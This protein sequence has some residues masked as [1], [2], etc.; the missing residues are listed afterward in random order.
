MSNST[1]TAVKLVDMSLVKARKAPVG[2][3]KGSAL[4]PTG[5]VHEA[6][7][8][9][10]QSFKK[11]V[12]IVK[13]LKQR[14]TADMPKSDD[15]TR[16]LALEAKKMEHLE[17]MPRTDNTFSVPPKKGRRCT[18]WKNGK[19]TEIYALT[20]KWLCRV[21][22]VGGDVAAP[23]SALY[24]ETSDLKVKQAIE[25]AT[26]YVYASGPPE[27]FIKRFIEGVNR[28]RNYVFQDIHVFQVLSELVFD[29]EFAAL[30]EETFETRL[31]EL[32][33]N[34][35]A[36]AGFPYDVSKEAEVPDDSQGRLEMVPVFAYIKADAMAYWDAC[37]AE[38]GANDLLR[39]YEE[40]PGHGLFKLKNKHEKVHLSEVETKIRP[41]YVPPAAPSMVWMMLCQWIGDHCPDIDKLLMLKGADPTFKV[42]T[43]KAVG[44]SWADGGC[45]RVLTHMFDLE[46]GELKIL[47]YTDD[48]FWM[49]KIRGKYYLAMIDIRQLDASLAAEYEKLVKAVVLAA[50]KQSALEAGADP[51]FPVGWENALTDLLRMALRGP[52]A[53]FKENIYNILGGLR[54]G[55][56]ITSFLNQVAASLMVANVKDQW[57][58]LKDWVLS[59]ENTMEALATFME[60]A[61]TA[62]S[63]LGLELKKETMVW[64]EVV[65]QSDFPESALFLGMRIFFRDGHYFPALPAEKIIASLWANKRSPPPA[66]FKD[67]KMWE[68]RQELERLRAYALVGGYMYPE[69]FAMMEKYFLS[70]RDKYGVYVISDLDFGEEFLWLPQIDDYLRHLNVGN[71][72]HFPTINWCK[73]IFTGLP[74][75]EEPM[76]IVQTE[77]APSGAPPRKALWADISNMAVRQK[78][79]RPGGEPSD[80]PHRGGQIEKVP[81]K[82]KNRPARKMYFAKEKPRATPDA[83]VVKKTKEYRRKPG[84]PPVGKDPMSRVL[85]HQSAVKTEAEILREIAQMEAELAKLQ[86]Q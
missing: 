20:N 54:S 21:D 45:D 85:Q 59:E 60:C 23:L 69:I 6:R 31:P 36:D 86:P 51:E 62:A 41:Y 18:V 43:S 28:P 40:C 75:K 11:A 3:V 46:E 84:P 12:G 2:G 39:F 24:A 80:A 68:R 78:M 58:G 29:S 1:F 15:I 65:P 63:D 72:P 53:V 82:W 17:M 16:R 27:G 38:H 33:Y 14:A 9:I 25:A 71:V 83:S 57:V 48:G 30:E 61:S 47:A 74:A 22:D 73:S 44:M 19:K 52:I 4:T 10:Q 67:A 8:E 76:P 37:R 81:Q 66:G 13:A 7:T 5:H 34:A 26:S 55:V 49:V 35:A 42:T 70:Q 79:P 50:Y 32:R 56:P 77:S 64:Y